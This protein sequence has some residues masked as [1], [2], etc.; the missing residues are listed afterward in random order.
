MK[1]YITQQSS[2][3]TTGNTPSLWV[4]GY[5]KQNNNIKGVKVG[6]TLKGLTPT[7]SQQFPNKC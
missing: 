7:H 5:Q 3:S 2:G 6:A 4:D 1:F